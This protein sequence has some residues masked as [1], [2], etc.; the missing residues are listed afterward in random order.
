MTGVVCASAENPDSRE[1]SH[2]Q[3]T[4]HGSSLECSPDHKIG[5][6]PRRSAAD[7]VPGAH[8]PSRQNAKDIAILK[9]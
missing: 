4:R 3:T 5:T 6:M 1:N 7:K 8:P 9:D 2:K